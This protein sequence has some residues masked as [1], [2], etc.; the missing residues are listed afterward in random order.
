MPPI[1]VSKA[2]TCPSHVVVKFILLLIFKGSKLVGWFALSIEGWNWKPR[3]FTNGSVISNCETCCQF[4][5]AHQRC[6]FLFK[7]RTREL[8]IGCSIDRGLEPDSS[9]HVA[10]LRTIL[11][12]GLLSWPLCIFL[13]ERWSQSSL[14]VSEYFRWSNIHA[15]S[16][17]CAGKQWDLCVV[18]NENGSWRDKSAGLH[19]WNKDFSC[20]PKRGRASKS[21]LAIGATHSQHVSCVAKE[22]VWP[23]DPQVRLKL[24]PRLVQ[25]S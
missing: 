8:L 6:Q 3:L 19:N 11:A 1:C 20:D 21:I 10:W 14:E 7:M 13:K 25:E 24:N 4:P 5:T 17:P 23:A 9:T 12:P 2:P 18:G 22:A 15:F 16:C